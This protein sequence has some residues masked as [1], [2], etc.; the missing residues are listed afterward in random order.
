LSLLVGCGQSGASGWQACSWVYARDTGHR[1]FD[2]FSLD[3][4]EEHRLTNGERSDTP[5]L[6]PDGKRIVFTRGVGQSEEC[7]GFPHTEL[8]VMDADGSD[9]RRL[10]AGEGDDDSPVW[11]PDGSMIAFVRAV[12]SRQALDRDSKKLLMVVPVSD[13]KAGKPRVVAEVTTY[14][15][16]AWSPDSTRLAWLELPPQ[17]IAPPRSEPPR[18]SPG[19]LD[20]SATG[21]YRLRSPYVRIEPPRGTRPPSP[22]PSPP[23]ATIRWKAVTGTESGKLTAPEG[24][25]SPPVWIDSNHLVFSVSPIGPS[26]TQDLVRV[27]IP[28]GTVTSVGVPVVLPAR[29]SNGRI[30]GMVQGDNPGDSRLVVVN[31]SGGGYQKVAKVR[32]KYP[33][34]GMTISAA[35]PD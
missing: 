2:V 12:P 35:C 20:P 27:R 21:P 6:S 1:L 15:V 24:A 25:N 8:Y 22:R 3:G 13:D 5:S 26:P 11:S 19:R 7:C 9:Q 31:Q 28:D 10:L 32:M 33:Y 29:M 23:R 4:G 17:P 34:R 30:A 18:E 16:P 14:D